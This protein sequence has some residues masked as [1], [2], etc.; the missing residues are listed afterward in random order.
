M[1]RMGVLP[2]GRHS[3]HYLLV[4][5]DP[6]SRRGFCARMGDRK[7]FIV[8]LFRAPRM[9]ACVQLLAYLFTAW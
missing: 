1:V 5:A 2:N 8:W 6:C 4:E 7:H 3:F 9:R